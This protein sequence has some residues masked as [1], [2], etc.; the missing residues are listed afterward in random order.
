MMNKSENAIRNYLYSEDCLALQLDGEWGSGKTFFVKTLV[1]KLKEEKDRYQPLLFSVNGCNSLEEIKQGI[2]EKIFLETS[3]EGKISKFLSN[4]KSKIDILNQVIGDTKFKSI[5]NIFEQAVDSTK[6]KIQDDSKGKVVIFIDDL[7]RLS[8]NVKI[9][10]L[11]GFISADLLEKYEYKVII[12]SNSLRIMDKEIY[13]EI[14]EKTIG[15]SSTYSTDLE[16]VKKIISDV[17][18]EEDA[19]WVYKILYDYIIQNDT[20]N[21]RTLLQILSNYKAIVSRFE[22][23]DIQENSDI[24]KSILL[25][26]AIITQEY[27]LG[28]LS[29]ENFNDLHSLL[30]TRSFH[31]IGIGISLKETY[32]DVETNK[33]TFAGSIYKKYHRLKSDYKEFL[34]YSSEI[35][36]YIVHYNETNMINY[37]E[38][39]KI[40]FRTETA[41]TVNKSE[42]LNNFRKMDD[43]ELKNI[44]Q[45]ILDDVKESKV[46]SISELLKIYFGLAQ[47]SQMGLM[48][49][50][51]NGEWRESF[52]DN[53]LF[54]SKI[55][56]FPDFDEEAMHS[57]S[58]EEDYQWMKKEYQIY[59]TEV[60]LVEFKK[61]R[62]LVFEESIN[63][64]QRS[65]LINYDY[66]DSNIIEEFCSDEM[67]EKYIL[68]ERNTADNLWQYFR[69][70]LNY[71]ISSGK[72]SKNDIE[73]AIH[74]IN[75]K[76]SS[77]KGK[78]D[79]FKINQL[80]DFLKNIQ[81]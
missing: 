28:N 57:F 63:A 67:I 81:Y 79:N 38:R 27:R 69:S 26:V 29:K 14:R 37:L 34:F 56:K 55:E 73:N 1:E 23:T 43:E 49:V 4:N 39:W 31:Q 71:F 3:V 15:S 52:K 25:N 33:E 42:S 65:F 64:E 8:S 77:V 76:K 5:S 35:N 74:K 32:P 54:L 48:L 62:K 12:I 44:Q 40:A 60:S 10:D 68:K 6:E 41:K 51:E 70:G 24:L 50:G 11:F 72:V 59:E 13:Q 16:V 75:S 45:S 61:I 22:Q 47:F 21:L 46:E 53:L 20:V 9:K 30:N 36:E 7:E 58:S 17:I 66:G 19:A 78:I 18:D 2:L 80:L